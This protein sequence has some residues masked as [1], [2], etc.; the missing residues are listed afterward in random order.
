MARISN[1]R[2]KGVCGVC[3][4]IISLT[5]KGVLHKHSDRETGRQC[6]GSSSEPVR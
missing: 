4:R 3:G 6:P 5:T 2:P 1:V